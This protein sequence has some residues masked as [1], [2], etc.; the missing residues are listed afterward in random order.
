M[1]LVMDEPISKKR[2]AIAIE[3]HWNLPWHLDC[4]QG[5]VDYAEDQGWQ[6]ITDP[7]LSGATGDHDLSIYDGVIGRID[8]PMAERAASGGC[9]AVTLLYGVDMHS[10]RSDAESCARLVGQHLFECG[11]RHLGFISAKARKTEM[12]QVILDAFSKIAATLGC[13]PPLHAAFDSDDFGQ[14]G[15]SMAARQALARWIQKQDKP[16]GLY[17]QD[18]ATARYLT[19]ICEQLGLR[20]PE[21]V[22]VLVHNA[23]KLTAT[24]ITPTLSEVLIDHW[25]QGYQAALILDRLM[26]GER[27]EPKTRYITRARIITRES[28]DRYISEDEMVS[29]AM[30]YIAEHSR[31]AVSAEDVAD[32][33]EVSRRT[34]DRRFEDL[35]GKTVSQEIMR[36]RI[37]QLEHAL[38]D[39]ELTMASIAD[40]FGFGSASQFTQFF[41]KQAGVTPSVFRKRY[42]KETP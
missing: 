33:L 3:L 22:G 31:Q 19:Q 4:Y 5:I 6:C 13:P 14:P 24:S 1:P 27:V 29:K 40:L 9:P 25:E 21:D 28:S 41:K 17:I 7:Y 10:V 23:D 2:I 42:R 30:R 32:A 12:C 20:V 8:P 26:Q 35:L 37:E 34:L 36:K 39:S 11:Y 15:K 38:I 18:M 16:I